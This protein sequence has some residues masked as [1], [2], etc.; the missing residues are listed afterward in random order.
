MSIISPFLCV[1]QEEDIG[2]GNRA[3]GPTQPHIVDS[4]PIPSQQF[5]KMQARQSGTLPMGALVLFNSLKQ[6]ES[7][8]LTT[9]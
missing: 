1:T 3:P 9:T 7:T 2:L 5:L 6:L 8:Q 4:P